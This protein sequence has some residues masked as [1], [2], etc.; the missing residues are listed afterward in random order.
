MPSHRGPRALAGAHA[1]DRMHDLAGAFALDALDERER[2]QFTRHLRR[3]PVCA[4]GVRGHQEVATALAFAASAEPPPELHD[5]VMAAVART[6]QLPPR[7]APWRRF[8]D[9]LPRIPAAGWVPRLAAVTAAAAIGAVVVLS[10]MLADARQQLNSVRAQSQVIAVVLA[11]PD[12]QTVAGSVTTGGVATVVLSA[13]RRELVVST[14]GMATLQAGKT[15]ELWLIGPSP[16]HAS[17]IRP[18]GLLPAAVGGRTTPV[19]AS[20]LVAGDKLGLTVEP[21]GGSSQPTTTPVLLLS[22]PGET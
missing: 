22:L 2:R 15:Y 17:A 21:A 9:R 11:A 5:R 4:A 13:G 8:A 16:A 12:V 7:L 20:G 3:C 1:R 18:A 14:S 19:L 6:G 10:V